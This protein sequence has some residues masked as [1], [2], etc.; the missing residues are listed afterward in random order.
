[1]EEGFK[2]KT[3]EKWRKEATIKI[4]TLLDVTEYPK[5]CFENKERLMII[6]I[7]K[8]D[9]ISSTSFPCTRKG[10]RELI[11]WLKEELYFK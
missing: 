5:G 3:K 8:P 4:K 7:E 9:V 11:K 1:M 10:E 2:P 6:N